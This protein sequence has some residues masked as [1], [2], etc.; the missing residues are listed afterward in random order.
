MVWRANNKFFPKLHTLWMHCALLG[1]CTLSLIGC[2][3]QQRLQGYLEGEY[4]YLASN[5]SG[6]LKEL[7]ITRGQNVVAGQLAYVLDLEPEASALQQA[8]QQLQQASNTLHDIE[9][10]Q[11]TTVVQ[12]IIAQRKQAAA[13]LQYAQVTRDRYRTLYQRG[14]IAKA[15]L[16]QAEADYQRNLNLVNQF[17]A[18]L[19]EAKLGARADQIK[20]Q[21]ATVDAAQ[22]AVQQAQ[23]RLQQKTITIP[24]AG[25]IN[26]TY[27]RP[28]EF[29]NAQQPVA[30]L[31]TPNNIYLVFY[32]P[33]PERSTLKMG[34]Q[35][36]F[37][38]D[39]CHQRF[40]ARINYIAPQAEYTP[41]VIFSRESRDKLVFR[42]QAALPLA[43]AQRFYPGQPVE[44]YVTQ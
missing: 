9:T 30:S 15:M 1:L 38:C 23:W 22:A 39:G 8:Q 14:S 6:I 35:I 41:P 13:D 17:T 37:S 5:A 29:V 25:M 40:T 4:I 20:A 28:G 10:G 27:Y 7:A 43:T 19:S 2:E 42:V 12:A 18:N 34:Q 26:D 3:R 21:L 11:R 44:V 31:L 16:D 36:H 24:A 33:E 32:I